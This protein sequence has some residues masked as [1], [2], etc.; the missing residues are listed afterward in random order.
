MAREESN[1][2]PTGEMR[3]TTCEYKRQ[4]VGPAALMIG[5]QH[6]ISLLTQSRQR[7]PGHRTKGRLGP[8]LREPSRRRISV[9]VLLALGQPAQRP[10]QQLR[11]N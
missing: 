7:L 11:D 5:V 1:N 8:R 6:S 4:F 9:L 3:R 2:T 10:H